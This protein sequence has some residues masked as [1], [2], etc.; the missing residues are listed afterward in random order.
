VIYVWTRASLDWSDEEAFWAQV[1][2]RFKPRAEL[3]N[4]TFNIPFHLFRHR[5]KQI[6]ELNLSRVENVVHAPWEEIPEGARVVPV[7]DDDWF[8][9]N[10]AQVLEREWDSEPGISW[11]GTW[12]GVPSVLE[13]RLHLM[14]RAVLPFTRP[15]W[16]CESNNYGMVKRA[17]FKP[18]L[19][20][21]GF[22]CEWFDGEGRESVKR[23]GERLN[24]THR[25]LASQ[26]SL[27]PTPRR[28]ELDRA[29]LLRRLRKYKR[30]YRRRPWGHGLEW[31]RPYLAMMAELTEELEPR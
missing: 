25:H 28:G 6:A 1:P 9:P 17:E 18:L 4:A 30:L 20:E 8:A 15:Y 24:V 23:F 10:L 12:I 16:T 13:H 3:W 26:T 11:T 2:P 31:C 21:H 29:R 22:A 14:K 7:D 5:V 19:V 27:R